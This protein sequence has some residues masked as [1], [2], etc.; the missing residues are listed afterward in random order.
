MEPQVLASSL[1]Q[2]SRLFLTF[3]DELCGQKE[4]VL[5]SHMMV[6]VLLSD[7]FFDNIDSNL[8]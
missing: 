6:L 4:K 1:D 3:H 8:A 5:M 2:G 7:S